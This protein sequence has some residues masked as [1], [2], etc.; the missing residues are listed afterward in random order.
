MIIMKS[1]YYTNRWLRKLEIV[2]LVVAIIATTLVFIGA[3]VMVLYSASPQS[4]KYINAF[5]CAIASIGTIFT[6][7]I[8]FGISLRRYVFHLE[9]RD[10]VI[11]ARFLSSIFVL[12]DFILYIWLFIAFLSFS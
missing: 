10:D 11:V 4:T 2:S 5:I 6:L 12:G 1:E 9:T 7:D 3:A 8:I